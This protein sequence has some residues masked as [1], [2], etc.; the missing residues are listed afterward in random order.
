MSKYVV[1]KPTFVE[2]L[3]SYTAIVRMI[4]Q[5][6]PG[7]STSLCSYRILSTLLSGNGICSL[8]KRIC[9]AALCQCVF[10][11]LTVTGW[12]H[13]SHLLPTSPHTQT[14]EKQHANRKQMQRTDDK[15]PNEKN[16]CTVSK[17]SGG[18]KRQ[19][20]HCDSPSVTPRCPSP[21]GWWTRAEP[22][23]RGSGSSLYW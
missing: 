8:T 23:S 3:N 12:F 17:G 22:G 1:I 6:S 20:F 16:K 18:K 2:D 11:P 4:L 5:T 14:I 21:P 15:V 7:G 9:S 19:V 13:A 10:V